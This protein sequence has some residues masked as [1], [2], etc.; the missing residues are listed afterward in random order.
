M[1]V[2]QRTLIASFAIAAA[3]AAVAFGGTQSLA[4]TTSIDG[5]TVLPQQIRWIAH[6]N[7]ASTS[8]SEVDYLIDG[9]LR[10][11][12]QYAPFN[13]GSDDEKGHL[14]YLYTSWLTPRPAQVH[15]ARQD[16]RRRDGDGRRYRAGGCRSGPA[17]IARRDLETG[18]HDARRGEGRPQ[19]REAAHWEVENSW[20]LT[21]EVTG[22][23]K[24][25]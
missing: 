2:T 20:S 12:E 24:R 22:T 17:R 19:I 1:G 8:V 3:F 21:R 11:V 13:Y 7:V 6:P 25:W 23:T 14:G 4:V 9:K 18:R 16:D 10:W 15:G 5:K